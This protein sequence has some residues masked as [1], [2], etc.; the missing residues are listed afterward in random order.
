M[1][2][3]RKT[4]LLKRGEGKCGKREAFFFSIPMRKE[5][6]KIATRPTYLTPSIFFGKGERER[7][8]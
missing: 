1:R 6:K 7:K 5:E 8:R 3:I 2:R 4:D